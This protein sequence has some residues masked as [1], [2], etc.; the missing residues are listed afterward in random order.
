[1]EGAMTVRALLATRTGDVISCTAEETVGTVAARL[2]EQ[3]IGAMPVMAGDQVIGIFSERDLLRSV[4][5]KGAAALDAPVSDVM[6]SPPITVDPDTAAIGA[7]SLMTKRRFRHLPVVEGD[8]MIGF[9]SIG[10]LV[11]HRIDQVEAEAS[12]M[13]DYIA[14]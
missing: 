9:I 11:K 7:L 5:A 4:V 12:A 8:R 1:M 3:R 10:D 2:V 6:A 13:R 14:Q